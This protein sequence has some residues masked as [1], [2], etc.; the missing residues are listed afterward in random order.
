MYLCTS[1]VGA[2]SLGASVDCW[3]QDIDIDRDINGV[4]GRE[5]A[6]W[7]DTVTFYR[8]LQLY[9]YIHIYIYI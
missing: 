2:S 3:T 6:V 1:G 7:R 8:D 9:I 5:G 4:S